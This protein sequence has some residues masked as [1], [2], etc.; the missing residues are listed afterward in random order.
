ME[1]SIVVVH[2]DELKELISSSV[3]E[4]LEKQKKE[5]LIADEKENILLT[6]KETAKLLGVCV[7]TLDNWTRE[8]KLTKYRNGNTVRY[9]K[10]EVLN[11]FS[12][13]KKYLR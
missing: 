11:S 1:K 8:G 6:R 9:S 4:Q 5:T 10:K 7:A 12:N 3:A 13:L 2:I